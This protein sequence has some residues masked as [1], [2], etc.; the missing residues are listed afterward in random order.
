M[1]ADHYVLSVQAGIGEDA[2]GAT[3][4]DVLKQMQARADDKESLG[5]FLLK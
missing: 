3:S 1:T 4:K 5:G 2:I